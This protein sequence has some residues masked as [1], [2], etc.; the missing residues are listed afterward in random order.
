MASDRSAE[1]VAPERTG[2]SGLASLVSDVSAVIDRTS[3]DERPTPE[4]ASSKVDSPEGTSSE[5]LGSTSPVEVYGEDARGD[6]TSEESS[7]RENLRSDGKAQSAVQEVK[8]SSSSV[9]AW[10]GV[11]VVAVIVLVSLF[12]MTRKKANGPA[13]AFAPAVAPIEHRQDLAPREYAIASLNANVRAR[14]STRSKVIG[15]LKRGSPVVEIEQSNGF[16]K[17][18]TND[19]FEG[20]IS[21]DILIEMANLTR[22]ESAS[23]ADYIASR[24]RFRPIERM[25]EH[26]DRLSPQVR[27]LLSQIEDRQD[28]AAMVAEIEGYDRPAFEAD[29]SAGL[30]FSLGARA[31]ADAGDH[32]DAIRL[33][34]AAI[35]ADPLKVEY[36]T[37]LGFSAIALG[38]EDRLEAAA[39]I[40]PA[41]APGATNTWIVVGVNAALHGKTELAHGAFLASLDR[42]RNRTTTVRVL[43]GL[44]ARSEAAAVV[45]A[46]NGALKASE[47]S[48]A[49]TTSFN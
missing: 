21:L 25:Y 3:S 31:A 11:L 12:D 13:Q 20:W 29:D 18:R 33:V 24:A 47:E 46:V 30:W 37:A 9:L 45:S 27:S 38:Q 2:F 36:H 26:L 42:S 22:L 10:V 4:D 35:Y 43:R 49:D 44:V 19:G 17:F 28:I 48:A 7:S 1:A 8:G 23:P 14:P 5:S 16:I 15:T 39:A 6:Q 40:L 41:L 32:V 34:I